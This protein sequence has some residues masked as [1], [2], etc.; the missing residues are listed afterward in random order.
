MAITKKS[1]KDNT[2]NEEKKPTHL[3]LIKADETVINWLNA[4]NARPSTRKNFTHGIAMYTEMLNMSPD[5][6]LDEAEAEMTLPARK[7]KLKNH[8]VAFRE[9]LQKKGVSEHTIRSRLT[10]VRSFYNSNEIL[11]PKIKFDKPTTIISNDQVPTKEDLQDCIS[12]CDPLEKAVMLTGISSGLASNELRSIKIQQFYNGY[13]PETG[14]TTLS[15]L[16]RQKTKVK[17]MTFLSPECSKAILE[18]IEY[19]N[20]PAKRPGILKQQQR[21]KQY[22]TKDSYLFIVKS[23]PDKYLETRDEEL[24]KM[25]ENALFNLYK[26][27]SEKAR[28]NTAKGYN[29]IRSH[30]MRKYFNSALLNAGCDA[31]HC[32]YWM[33][34]QLNETQ[35]AYFRANI[36]AQ[37][38][39]YKKYIPYL[40]IEK[41]LDISV[42]PE[43]KAALERAEKAE[44]EAARVSVERIELQEMRSKLE[45][46]ESS[47]AE[48]EK[49]YREIRN[50]PEGY[51]LGTRVIK[52]IHPN[53]IILLPD[54]GSECTEE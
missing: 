7:R 48:I 23:V 20:R 2:K 42:S 12:I 38:E 36:Q 14:I 29:F 1:K 26:G 46:A 5:A 8:I 33:G 31:F 53:R 39:L 40:T 11:I 22:T 52:K 49:L 43:Y 21:E 34:H 37:K 51:E 54:D 50:T 18:Y 16:Y 3:D 30:T 25:G 17:F 47:I 6:L 44:A 10:A 15:N 35:A 4:I 32:E 28:K 13:D 9:Q 27:I 19:R 45:L 41:S 24:R